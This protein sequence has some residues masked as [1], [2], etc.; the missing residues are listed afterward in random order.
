[1][2]CKHTHPSTD[3]SVPPDPPQ[4]DFIKIRILQVPLPGIRGRDIT[5]IISSAFF[6]IKEIVII[7]GKFNY[8]P[9][10]SFGIFWLIIK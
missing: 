8:Y 4:G 5:F 10:S 6:I 2:P 1:M 3:L 9:A 7:A